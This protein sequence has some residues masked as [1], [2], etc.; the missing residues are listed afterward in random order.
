MVKEVP[1]EEKRIKN[2]KINKNEENFINVYLFTHTIF[3]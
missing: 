1:K 3:V 2:L